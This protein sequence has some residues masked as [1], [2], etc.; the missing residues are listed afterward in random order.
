MNEKQ[1]RTCVRCKIAPTITSMALT[2]AAC[3]IIED[4]DK[5]EACMQF[6]SAID[7]SKL[8][9]SAEPI[10]KLIEEYGSEVLDQLIAEM[11]ANVRAGVVK[12]VDKML[13]EGKPVSPKLMAFYREVKA[14]QAV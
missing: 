1:E 11:N 6:A 5:R 10:A 4:K 12:A 2:N 14:R 9:D 13:A 8:E 3:Q 7:F